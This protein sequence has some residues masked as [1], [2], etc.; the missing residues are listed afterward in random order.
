[1]RNIFP[2]LVTSENDCLKNMDLLNY[3]ISYITESAI[4]YNG[5]VMKV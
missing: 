2:F 4:Y 1:M 3:A 5:F